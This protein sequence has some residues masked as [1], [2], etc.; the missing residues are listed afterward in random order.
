MKT[1][2][3]IGLLLIGMTATLAAEY[4]NGYTRR[5]GTYVSGY[6]RTPPDSNPYNNQAYPGNY[7]YNTGRTTPGDQSDYLSDY[8]SRPSRNSSDYSYPTLDDLSGQHKRQK[9]NTWSFDE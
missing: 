2:T 5:D 1:I 8:Y 3:M 9:S 4:V 6:Y 7:N